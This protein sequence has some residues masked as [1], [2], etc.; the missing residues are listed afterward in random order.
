MISANRHIHTLVSFVLRI[1]EPS[2]EN[3]HHRQSAVRLYLVLVAKRDQNPQVE[4]EHDLRRALDAIA[5]VRE[6]GIGAM[7]INRF[8][9]YDA[10]KMCQDCGQ[11]SHMIGSSE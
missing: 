5:M 1:D 8:S 11:A 3:G 2:D 4:V 7:L 6:R 10:S 9:A